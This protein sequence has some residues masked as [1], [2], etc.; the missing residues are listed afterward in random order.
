MDRIN[1]YISKKQKEKLKAES[2][3]TGISVSE[4]IRRSIDKVYKGKSND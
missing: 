3:R 4:L 2:K 1:I